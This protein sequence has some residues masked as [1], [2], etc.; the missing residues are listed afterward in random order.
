MKLNHGNASE[1]VLTIAV[2][3]AVGVLALDARAEK[4]GGRVARNSEIT[5]LLPQTEH[6]AHA[7]TGVLGDWRVNCIAVDRPSQASK[8]LFPTITPVRNVS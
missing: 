5:L 3:A 2:P 7:G 1:P 8:P 4:N 6:D